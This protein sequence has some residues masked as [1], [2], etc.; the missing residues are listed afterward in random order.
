[1]YASTPSAICGAISVVE[2]IVAVLFIQSGQIDELALQ[3]STTKSHEVVSRVVLASAGSTT[4]P[5]YSVSQ[6]SGSVILNVYVSESEISTQTNTPPVP[7]QV[8]RKY[9]GFFD[10]KARKLQTLSFTYL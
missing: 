4:T 5:E 10:G 3:K 9:V 1:M 2:R 6:P 7:P 8:I